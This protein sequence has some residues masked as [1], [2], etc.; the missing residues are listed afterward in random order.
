M[1]VGGEPRH[2]V[3]LSNEYV[4]ALRVSF[5]PSDTTWAHRHAEDSLYFFLVEG[6]LDVV[7]HVQGADPACDC[8]EFGEIRFGTHKSDKPLVH[9]IT[10]KSNQV[11]LCIDAEVLKQPPITAAIPLVAEKHELVKTRDKCRVYKL[12][13]EPGESV[14]VTYPFFF[15]TVVLQGGKLKSSIT[16]GEGTPSLSW[17]TSYEKG[18]V[19][20]K[21]PVVGL[22]QTNVGDSTFSLYIAE[23]R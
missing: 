19:H 16:T 2:N 23:W 18:D 15:F 17:T 7:N 22:T 6:G 14:T 3:G 9:K 20:W 1:E 21:E 4:R 5:P 12:S 8:M 10:N 11:M 13:L